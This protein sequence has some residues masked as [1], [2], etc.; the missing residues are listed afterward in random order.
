MQSIQDGLQ[1][2]VVYLGINF[3][4]FTISNKYK[5]FTDFLNIYS[6]VYMPPMQNCLDIIH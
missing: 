6:K 5:W 4:A 3:G 2:S 1:S